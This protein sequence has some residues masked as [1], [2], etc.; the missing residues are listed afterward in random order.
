MIDRDWDGVISED[1]IFKTLDVVYEHTKDHFD[2]ESIDEVKEAISG[3]RR[4]SEDEEQENPD[5]PLEFSEFVIKAIDESH[6][7]NYEKLA[8]S[9]RHFDTDG[10]GAVEAKELVKALDNCTCSK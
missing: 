5:E 9:F 6:L 10:S 2:H 4:E 1:D 3:P 7:K 8:T